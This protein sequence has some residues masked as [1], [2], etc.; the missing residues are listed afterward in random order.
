MKFRN[1]DVRALCNKTPCTMS[2][3]SPSSIKRIVS[4]AAVS[5]HI[6]VPEFLR[7][8]IMITQ[9]RNAACIRLYIVNGVH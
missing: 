4:C 2:G 7:N 6:Y 5:L 9:R 3:V 8:R 1:I